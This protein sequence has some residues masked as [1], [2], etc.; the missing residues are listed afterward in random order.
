[1]KRPVERVLEETLRDLERRESNPRRGPGRVRVFRPSDDSHPI[2][3]SPSPGWPVEP[4]DITI[5][6]A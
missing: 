5:Q 3:H 1:M 6:K 2:P 4:S